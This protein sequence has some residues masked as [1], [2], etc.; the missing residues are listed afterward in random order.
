MTRP[1]TRASPRPKPASTEA[2]FRLEVTGSAVNRMPAACGTTICCTTT[3]IADLAVIKAVPQAV[4]HCPLAEQRGPAPADVLE[5]GRRAHD[6]QVGVV[7]AG[8]GCARQVLRRRTGSDGAGGVLAEPGERVRDRRRQILRDGDPFEG[9]ADLRAE[10]A[11]RLPVVRLQAREPIEPIVDRR[12]LRQDPLGRRPSSRRSRPAHGCLRS[13]KA[14]PGARPCRR[15]PQPGSGRS[16]GNPTRSAH[17]L[18]SLGVDPVN[19]APVHWFSA[20]GGR[21]CGTNQGL[22][23]GL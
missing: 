11:D 9:P 1:E 14:P 6:V 22:M 23:R 13:A 3:A 5:D 12:R 18:I 20:F 4:G 21:L 7:L 8:E 2:T 17:P 16:P 19:S 15:R 10:R